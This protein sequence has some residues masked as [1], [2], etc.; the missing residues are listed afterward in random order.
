[1]KQKVVK[2]L[3]QVLTMALAIVL[4]LG[5]ALPALAAPT[6]VTG[7]S[8]GNH[9][10]ITLKKTLNLADNL[11]VPSATF[12]YTLTPEDIDGDDE[13]IT[14]MPAISVSDITFSSTDTAASTEDGVASYSKESAAFPA[15]SV[16][17]P[18]AGVY[19]YTLAETPNTYIPG[20]TETITYDNATYIVKLYVKNGSNGCYVDTVEAW[21]T[22]DAGQPEAK[23]DPTPGSS[24]ME[25]VNNYSKT[26]GSEDPC[27][28]IS[29]LR[30]LKTVAGDYA[31]KS[32]YFTFTVKVTAP[33][34]APAAT[35][36]A[37]VANYDPT[38]DTYTVVTS[39][40]NYS[41]TIQ[42][43]TYGNYIEF[44]SGINETI[45]LKHYQT[46]IFADM[47]IGT[48]YEMQ[49]AATPDYK[50]KVDLNQGGTI[51]S[52]TAP[53]EN[54]AV[55]TNDANSGN[56]ARIVQTQSWNAAAFEN[57]HAAAPITPTGV[58]IDNLP[59]ILLLAVAVGA[60]ILFV[61]VKARRRRGY[62]SR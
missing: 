51:T 34:S 57:E 45:K 7:G 12:Q 15:N 16:T 26:T 17:F 54:M 23:I 40:D 42:N 58:I 3:K 59:F 32:K 55:S 56:E 52:Y 37:Y 22:D 1:M 19:T 35:Y 28:S 53:G 5:T 47:P 44:T 10:K 21:T 50:G 62:T 60:L 4:C 36:K 41:G 11:T 33:S 27:E 24:D 49:E 8:E 46:L 25:F 20:A 61:A 14:V 29:N 30:L 39:P 38:R 48:F 18:R 31:D 43:D 9:A 2:F 6:P 13:Q